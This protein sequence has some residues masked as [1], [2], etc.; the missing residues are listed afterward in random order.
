[1]DHCECGR[2]LIRA[3][4]KLVDDLE[5]VVA[6]AST[7]EKLEHVANI[8]Q[9]RVA[10]TETVGVRARRHAVEG[11]NLALTLHESMHDVRVNAPSSHLRDAWVNMALAMI[12]MMG[13]HLIRIERIT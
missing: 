11:Y 1:M 5:E 3:D 9:D 4:K 12:E 2:S 10:G 8:L 13:D 6:L 7:A